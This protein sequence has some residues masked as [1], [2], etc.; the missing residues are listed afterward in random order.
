MDLFLVRMSGFIFTEQ[1]SLDCIYLNL[2]YVTRYFNEGST[3]S[4]AAVP[5]F[6]VF[7]DKFDKIAKYFD[8]NAGKYIA[9]DPSIVELL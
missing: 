6:V 2:E 1:P 9:T 3:R 7:S 4:I 5:Y 8:T